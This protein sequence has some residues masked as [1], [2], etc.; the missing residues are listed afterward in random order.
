MKLPK[1]PRD[2]G[3]APSP[4]TVGLGFGHQAALASLKLFPSLSKARG[5]YWSKREM[6]RDKAALF[7]Q[8]TLL[9]SWVHINT[10]QYAMQ[11]TLLFDWVADVLLI[12]Q[13]R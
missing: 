1:R 13:L 4:D 7:S 8:P 3:L 12:C 2:T 5:I 11:G 9:L 6:C 10:S